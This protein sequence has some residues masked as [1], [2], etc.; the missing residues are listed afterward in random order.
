MMRNPEGFCR[1]DLAWWRFRVTHY[2]LRHASR[3][4]QQ[5]SVGYALHAFWLVSWL[6]VGSR[7]RVS[8]G[9]KRGGMAA[10]VAQIETAPETIQARGQR[11][12]STLAVSVHGTCL[13]WRKR[14]GH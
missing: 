8:P 3:F 4:T 2:V 11:K 13:L 7:H 1:N 12:H 9:V 5:K 14:A 10:K 6:V